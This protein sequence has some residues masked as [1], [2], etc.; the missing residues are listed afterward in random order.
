VLL[1]PGRDTATEAA[2]ASIDTIHDAIGDR[3]SVFRL[4]DDGEL[5]DGSNEPWDR[6][7]VPTVEPNAAIAAAELL[8]FARPG[9]RWR[10]ETLAPRLV[11]IAA[12]P[13]AVLSLAGYVL[14]DDARAR[15]L[16]V[17]A[18]TLPIER[19]DLMLRT[20]VEAAATLVRSAALDAETVA[21]L[22]RPHGDAVVWSRLAKGGAVIRSSEVVA[23]VLLDERRH[24]YDP[25]ARIDALVTALQSGTTARLPGA[26]LLRRDLLRR[27]Y[28]EP[29][30]GARVDL[31]TLLGA[32]TVIDADA[33]AAVVADLQWALERLSA[34]LATERVGWPGHHAPEVEPDEMPDEEIVNLRAYAAQVAH[35]W[36]MRGTYIEQL[37]AEIEVRD[38][39]ISRLESELRHFHRRR[40]GG[41]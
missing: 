41:R 2:T 6:L 14:V 23:E 25:R 34:T 29:S 32:A 31:T 26:S 7:G 5:L 15:V 12:N 13:E 27:L 4:T 19:I 8:A 37:G 20:H 24:G 10:P 33:G 28:L 18:P 1:L 35:E 9:D 22:A 21:L 40:A 39:M 30:T 3:A 38:A 17:G 11:E 16:E 36:Q